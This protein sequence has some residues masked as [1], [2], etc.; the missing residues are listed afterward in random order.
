MFTFVVGVD[1]DETRAQAQAEALA[2]SPMDRDDSYVVLTHSFDE[3]PEGGT[4]EQVKSVRLA[5]ERLEEA[6]YEVEAE[7]YGGD[8]AE[9]ILSVADE[10][11]A[12]RIVLAGR[13]RSP[14]GKALFG[15]VTQN[16]ILNTDRPV[17]V[18][19]SD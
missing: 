14:T 19:N 18:C 13:K 12:D 5:R 4:I 1:T 11:D 2:E 3:N 16:V 7:G 17:L 15:S 9:A 8:P 6:G 10:H